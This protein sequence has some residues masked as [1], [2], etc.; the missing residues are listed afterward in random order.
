MVSSVSLY[1]LCGLS[2]LC[3]PAKTVD[4]IFEGG[5]TRWADTDTPK[6]ITRVTVDMWELK[7]KRGSSGGS[8]ILYTPSVL[9][10]VHF[11]FAMCKMKNLCMEF[12]IGLGRVC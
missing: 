6:V 7:L 10:L 3:S 11:K 12:R 2:G 1:S 8:G 9:S 5:G 4:F